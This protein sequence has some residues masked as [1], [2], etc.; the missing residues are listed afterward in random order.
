M[1]VRLQAEPFDVA[2]EIAVLV[3]GRTDIGAVVTF[4]GLCRASEGGAPVS[5][6]TLE[7]YPGMAEEEIAVKPPQRS[8]GVRCQRCVFH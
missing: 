2:A 8:E 4:T 7:H 1:A 6:L 3:E 5:A